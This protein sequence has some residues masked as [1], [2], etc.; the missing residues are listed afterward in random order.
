MAKLHVLQ[1]TN[2]PVGGIRRHVFDILTNLNQNKFV[3]SYAY[4]TKVSDSRF[5]IG[6]KNLQREL[7][8]TI[9]LNIVKKPH[10]VDILNIIRL[11][12][13]VRRSQVDILHGHGA[14]GGV[15]ARVVGKICSVPAVYTPHGGIVHDIFSPLENKLYVWS[16]RFL[17]PWT[18]CFIFVS[19]YTANKYASKI[20]SIA[21]P[22]CVNHNGI[23]VGDIEDEFLPEYWNNGNTVDIGVFGMLRKIKGQRYLVQAFD[24]LRREHRDVRN[25]RLHIFGEGPDRPFI[26]N[27]IGQ[28]RLNSQVSLYGDVPDVEMKMRQ[29]DIIVIPSLYDAFP[30]VAIEA[31]ALGKP[32]IASAQ[33]G[34]LEILDEEVAVLVP[35]GDVESLKDALL[36]YMQFPEIAHERGKEGRKRCLDIFSLQRMLAKLE[37]CYLMVAHSQA[38]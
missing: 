33:G 23:K 4:S 32:I 31:M 15:Y 5:H 25:I 14:K 29:M 16:E 3:Q 7:Y 22:W 6:M 37:E 21:V 34:L 8:A 30:Y 38:W 26:E 19:H 12:K 35:P 27:L 18:S 13:F 20:G 17:Q 28:Y 36:F 2:E 24:A 9:P 1:I 10:Y 11:A